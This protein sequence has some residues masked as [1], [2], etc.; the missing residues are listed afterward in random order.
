MIALDD[1]HA[2]QRLGQPAGN[3]G[4]DL[5]PLAE[6]GANHLEAILQNKDERAHHCEDGERDRSAAMQQKKE[7]QHSGQQAAD[8]LHQPGADQVAHAFHVGHDARY[9][10]AGAVFIVVSNRQ[11]AHVPLH[12]PA[13]LGDQPLA[14]LGEQLRQ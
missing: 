8:K 11:Q 3:L 10:R 1:A 7:H 9:Q 2:A 4:V 14:G 13:H 12:L 5:A 6:D